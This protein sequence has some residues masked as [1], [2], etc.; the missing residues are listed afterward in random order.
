[1]TSGQ[2]DTIDW[3]CDGYLRNYE[4]QD[5]DD[6]SERSGEGRCS[7]EELVDAVSVCITV[8][9]APEAAVIERIKE[10]LPA[11]LHEEV[12]EALSEQLAAFHDL[13]FLREKDVGEQRNVLCAAFETMVL[14]TEDPEKVMNRLDLTRRKLVIV[15]K[16]MNTIL[17]FIIGLRLSESYARKRVR[18]IM[19]FSEDVTA[20]IVDLFLSNRSDL[21][22]VA[23][24]RRLSY[25]ENT[26][27]PIINV[28][29]AFLSDSEWEQ[30]VPGDQSAD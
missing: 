1:M 28:M 26:I 10:Q 7:L 11:E 23:L 2:Q 12:L 17:D 22:F 27:G 13:S 3:L 30:E 5:G 24:N 16:A 15:K 4:A 18:E 20:F 29:K 8:D 6:P 14:R 21:E 9:A 25:I 19:G